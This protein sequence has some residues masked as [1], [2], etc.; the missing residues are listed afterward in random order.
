MTRE[1]FRLLSLPVGRLLT[2][3]F[4]PCKL[5]FNYTAVVADSNF[6]R[7]PLR[8]GRNCSSTMV[9]SRSIP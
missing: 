1:L 2:S 4:G 6:S 3:V 8:T 9:T 5:I 7:W